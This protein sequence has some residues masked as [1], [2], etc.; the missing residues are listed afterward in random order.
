MLYVRSAQT[1]A[2]VAC[3]DDSGPSWPEMH[4]F[5]EARSTGAA[6]GHDGERGRAPGVQH[7]G[8]VQAAAA[9]GFT[10]V[11]CMPNT[12]PVADNAG[13]IELINNAAQAP[14]GKVWEFWLLNNNMK[15]PYSDQF[16]LSLRQAIGDWSAEVGVQEVRGY[17]E[18][19]WTA[20]GRNPDGS[21]PSGGAWFDPAPGDAN[22]CRHGNPNVLTPDVR[23]SSFA[24][25]CAGAH[26]LFVQRTCTVSSASSQLLVVR[27]DARVAS[28]LTSRRAPG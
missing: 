18:F 6:R 7:G 24:Q 16:G 3:D 22:L 15:M 1:G 19:L 2:Q 13:T 11:V 8:C 17:N 20:G 10:T 28:W 12:S 21:V 26:A 4:V 27:W 14:D 5:F 25:G 23:T 9:G